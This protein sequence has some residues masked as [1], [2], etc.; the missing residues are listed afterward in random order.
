MSNRR[1]FIKRSLPLAALPLIPA[2]LSSATP[3]MKTENPKP[4]V[5]F[6]DVNETLLDLEPLKKSVVEILGNNKALG[7]L[8]FT[9]MLQYSLVTS[10]GQQYFDFGQIGAAALVMVAQNNGITL[11]MEK[12]LN[13]VKPILKLEPHPE[14]KE[15]LEKLKKADF[16]LVSFTNS[17]SKAVLSQLTHAKIDHLF[18]EKISVEDFGRFKPEKEV[19]DWAA[20]KMKTKPEN[21]MLVAAHGWD[22][23]G[24][25]WAG[26]KTAFIAR[27]GQQ[28]FPLAPAPEINETD[29]EKVA[30]QILTL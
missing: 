12:A 16:K 5:I 28:L 17:S 13:A 9:T 30:A 21:C 29:L 10:A 8:W 22:V 6:F 27:K 19:Y 11:S 26:W 1:D 3:A 2:G 15:A 4:Q 23:A 25:A 20:R 18:D 7:T 14:V 24:A